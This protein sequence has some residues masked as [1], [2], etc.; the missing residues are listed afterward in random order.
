MQQFFEQ[1]PSMSGNAEGALR[2]PHYTTASSVLESSI[3]RSH[4]RVETT[5]RNNLIKELSDFEESRHATDSR[6]A[7]EARPGSLT[8]AAMVGRL[9]LVGAVMSIVAV[10][11]AYVG[12]WLSPHRPTQDRMLQVFQEVN[13]AHPGFRRNHAKGVCVSGWFD[14]SGAAVSLSK[15]EVVQ[16]GKRAQIIGRLALAGWMPGQADTPIEVRSMALRF[17]SRAGSEWRTG[18]N[19]IPVFT[20]NSAQGFYDQLLA[21]RTDPTTG[22]PDPAA[23]QAFLAHH[24]ETVRA[25]ALIKA[26]TIS[27]GFADSTFNS[28]DAFRFVNAAGVSTPVRWAM[29]PLQPVVAEAPAQAA[30]AAKNYLFDDLV[31]QI[32]QHPLKWRLMVTMGQPGDPTSD[33]TLPWPMQRQRINAGT[34]TL[35]AVSSEDE[36]GACT[37]INYDPLVLPAG[38]EGSDDPLLSARS[39]TYAGSFTLRAEEKA[40]KTPSAVMPREVRAGGKS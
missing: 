28:L 30:R 7:I 29:A 23:L 40:R 18:M 3:V 26:R 32:R 24:P 25:M 20:V 9:T 4:D 19:N 17:L 21:G 14:S 38:I 36:G 2:R 5:T 15:A 8:P 31:A 34:L 22:K 6:E 35:D 33:A 39:A 10:A 13:G 27:S 1:Q 12:G 11:F 16:A 37:D